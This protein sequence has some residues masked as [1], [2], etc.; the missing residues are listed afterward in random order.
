[1]EASQGFRVAKKHKV[2]P[3][4]WEVTIRA[5]QRSN[6]QTFQKVQAAA[7]YPAPGVV[8]GAREVASVWLLNCSCNF[9]GHQPAGFGGRQQKQTV[10]E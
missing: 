4:T 2:L 6:F 3:S 9:H 7:R 1:M 10:S 8:P 5:R